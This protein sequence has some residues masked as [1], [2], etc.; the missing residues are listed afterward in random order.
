MEAYV[1][2]EGLEKTY[3]GGFFGSPVQ[4]LRGISF[5]VRPGELMGLLGPNGAGK[6]T[7]VKILSGLVVPTAGEAAARAQLRY[8]PER[9][10]W[11]DHLTGIECLEREGKLFDLPRAERRKR[12]DRDVARVR[13]ERSEEH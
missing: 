13:L 8:L 5:A 2:V 3:P 12:I 6:T 4:A 1:E 7:T 11:P 10:L 9:A